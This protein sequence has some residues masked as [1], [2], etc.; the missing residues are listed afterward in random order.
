MEY[1]F[2]VFIESSLFRK[3]LSAYL[4]DDEYSALQYYLA[5]N[6]QA[7]QVI[8]GSSGLRKVRWGTQG[9]GKSGGVRVIY[10]WQTSEDQIFLL[11][12]Y[13][14]NEVSDLS[15]AEVAALRKMVEVWK[16]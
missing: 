8:R 14:K 11:T 10:Y 2:M 15:P 6:P 13:A 5:D 9:K 7:G 3:H 12:L 1:S 4:T 16:R